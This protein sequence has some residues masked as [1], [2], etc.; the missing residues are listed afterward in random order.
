[1]VFIRIFASLVYACVCESMGVCNL[2]MHAFLCL[3]GCVHQWY[4]Y[5]H[6]N[7]YVHASKHIIMGVQCSMGS[8]CTGECQCVCIRKHVCVNYHLY[9]FCCHYSVDKMI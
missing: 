5:A 9:L 1:M 4:Y 8:L 2:R 6:V 3:W 7:L